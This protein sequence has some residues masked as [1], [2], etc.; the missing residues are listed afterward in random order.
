MPR[1]YTKET[2]QN[3]LF[4]MG[5][6]ISVIGEYVD[7]YTKIE[8]NCNK[9]NIRYFQRPIDVVSRGRCGCKKCVSEKISKSMTL[10]HE[11]FLNRLFEIN[12]DIELLSTY[13]NMHTKVRCR[14]KLD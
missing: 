9:H 4:D 11:E 8:L 1:K 12:P 10:S 5:F 14:C 2:L 13:Q 7:C 3:K 6:N